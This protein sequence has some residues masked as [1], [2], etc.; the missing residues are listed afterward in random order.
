MSYEFLQ[1][2]WCLFLISNIW[3]QKFLAYRGHLNNLDV[4]FAD[5]NCAIGKPPSFSKMSK[6]KINIIFYVNESIFD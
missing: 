2:E 6:N 4:N 5:L 3:V 1:L